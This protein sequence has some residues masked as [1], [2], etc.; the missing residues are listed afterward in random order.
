[1]S[2]PDFATGLQLKAARGIY[3]TA[4]QEPRGRAKRPRV[5]RTPARTLSR[6]LARPRRL[7]RA[8]V[9]P[10]SGGKQ[11]PNILRKFRAH[12]CLL[13]SGNRTSRHGSSNVCS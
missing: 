13:T 10:L 9:S 3:A 11:T 2:P 6:L 4:P 12:R 1:M 7:A 5:A 8:S